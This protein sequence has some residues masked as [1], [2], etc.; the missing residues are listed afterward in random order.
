MPEQ[1]G[2]D[3]PKLSFDRVWRATREGKSLEVSKAS[4]GRILFS[5]RQGEQRISLLLDRDE[6]AGMVLTLMGVLMR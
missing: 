5:M 3:R 1:V 4:D 6:A 2:Y